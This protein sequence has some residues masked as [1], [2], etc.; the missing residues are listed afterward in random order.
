MSRRMHRMAPVASGAASRGR[1]GFTLIEVLVALAVFTMAAVMLASAY[2]NILNGYE[3]MSHSGEVNADL[4]FARSIVLTE[5]DRTKLEPGGQ[6]DTAD[7]NRAT[8]NVE[9]TSTNEADLFTVALTVE[10]PVV[11]HDPQQT[12][13]TFTVLRPTW[14]VDAAEHDKLKEDAKQ[15]ILELQGKQQ[16]QQQSP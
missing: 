7:G 8:W 12:T 14:T 16:Q 11:G 13:E 9:I 3:I 5:P 15:R 4:A 2:L 1:G 10:I 6:F